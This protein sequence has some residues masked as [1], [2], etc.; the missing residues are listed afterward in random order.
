MQAVLVGIVGPADPVAL[1]E[2]AVQQDEVRLGLA[3]GLQQTRRTFGKQMDDLAG[4]GVVVAS[5][6][7]NPAAIFARVVCSRRYTSAT[8]AR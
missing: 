8:G 5:P 1:S 2:R 3:Q 6:I 4:V 7:P